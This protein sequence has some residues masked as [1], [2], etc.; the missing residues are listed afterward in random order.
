MHQFDER[1]IA[2]VETALA[3]GRPLLVR[4]EPGLGKSQLAKA[5]AECLEWNFESTAVHAGTEPRDLLWT[6]DAVGRLAKAQLLAAMPESLRKD[7]DVKTALAEDAFTRP[8]IL[9]WAFDWSSAVQQRASAEQSLSLADAGARPP[10]AE[11]PEPS[12][13]R[14]VVVLIDEIDK[15]DASVP[16]ALLEALADRCFRTPAGQT[17][18]LDLEK[19]EAPLIVFTTNEERKLPNAFL[20]RCVVLRLKM[21]EE[22]ELVVRARK[23]LS[24]YLARGLPIRRG[25]AVCGS[26]GNQRTGPYAARAGG[27]HRPAGGTGHPVSEGS[28]KATR[29]VAAAKPLCVRQASRGSGDLAR[30]R[31]MTRR[32][33]IWKA[34]LLDLMDAEGEVNLFDAAALGFRRATY[35]LRASRF[36]QGASEKTHRPEATKSRAPYLRLRQMHGA[37]GHRFRF[38][39]SL[40]GRHLPNKPAEQCRRRPASVLRVAVF[41]RRYPWYP[42]ASL[43]PLCFADWPS[44]GGRASS[45]SNDWFGWLPRAQLSTGSLVRSRRIGHVGSWSGSIAPSHLGRSTRINV[46][47]S[48]SCE[49]ALVIRRFKFVAFGRGRS[50]QRRWKMA[51]GRRPSSKRVPKT[52]ISWSPTSAPVA[53]AFVKHG[54]SVV[55][56][57]EI[58]ASNLARSFPFR[59]A[60]IVFPCHG[61]GSTGWNV[62]SS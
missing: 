7:V 43:S 62:Q 16:N 52:S 30:G 40:G 31:L 50:A 17:V 22:A 14:G 6:F 46:R 15:A 35:L 13:K 19:Q 9:W 61:N 2:A 53:R 26:A 4:G 42:S 5:S 51:S 44:F 48:I 47:W 55:A 24:E 59:P 21:P 25:A 33:S 58:A 20:R 39:R 29:T 23:A 41:L 32:H 56:A 10:T 37:Q 18:K 28:G 12:E 34:D 60:C 54:R 36:S 1:S 8:G 49:T 27:V 38:F 11:Q 45:I 57:C 3:A